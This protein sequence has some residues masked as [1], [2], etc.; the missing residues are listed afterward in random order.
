MKKRL[1]ISLLFLCALVAAA[2]PKGGTFNSR[3]QLRKS[4]LCP[5]D[6]IKVGCYYYWVNE[7]VDP[8]GVK[9]DLQWMKDN[10][11]TLAF[12]ATDC[13]IMEDGTTIRFTDDSKFEVT[14]PDGTHETWDP[15]HDEGQ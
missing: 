9:A 3:N 6:S 14:F 7:I 12:L 11:I 1:T 2:S 15:V 4:F 5:P 10:G 8:K 13:R